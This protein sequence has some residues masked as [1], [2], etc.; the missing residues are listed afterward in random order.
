MA[1]DPRFREHVFDDL[2]SGLKTNPRLESDPPG[3]EVDWIAWDSGFRKTG[4][5]VGD[6]ILAVDGAPIRKPA[7]LRELQRQLP[8]M[9]GQYAEQQEFADR[10]LKDGSPLR[11]RTRRRRSPGEGWEE[12]DVTGAVRADRTWITPSN[13]RLFGPGG[14]DQLANDGFDGPWSGWLE[15][16]EFEWSRILNGGWQGSV[17]TRM[18]LKSH[19]EEKSRVDFLVQR[20]PGPFAD[21]VR[22]D[23]ET[24]RVCLE[25]ERIELPPDALVFRTLGEKRAAQVAERA[26]AAWNTFQTAHAAEILPSFPKID[27]FRGDRSAVAGKWVVL[28]A[29]TPRQ[30][31]VDMG[32]GFLAWSDSGFWIFASA[33]SQ[34]MV[35]VF[36]AVHRY[37]KLVTPSIK[38]DVA[39]IGQIQSDPR[40]LAGSGRTAAGL[41]VLPVA[42]LAGGA[43]FVEVAAGHEWD[44]PFA[45]EEDLRGADPGALP[46]DASPREVVEAMI[47]AIKRGDQQ[48][49]A[50]LFAEWRAVPDAD[51]P[52]YYPSYA[53]GVG[54]DEDWIRSRRLLMDKVLD[55]RVRWVGD[56][57]VVIRGDE[58]PGLPNI[59]QIPVEVDHVGLF[60]GETRTFNSLE[61]HRNWSL[62]RRAGGPWRI[63]SRQ[64]L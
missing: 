5:K 8:R 57:R 56:P 26:A 6:L 4:L 12:Q 36:R 33:D 7:E 18:A 16:R 20:Y 62:Q 55:A 35:R 39:V 2:R 11:L 38:E 52:I 13:R 60:D 50:E 53:W 59:E 14:P 29:I 9:I 31:L 34:G 30:W 3:L 63:A 61:V 54:R 21:T 15:R 22:E 40:L 24:V 1:D 37:Q 45:G 51:R 58:A 46:E 23:W 32:R 25:G 27:P 17:Q 49:W 47:A 28:P 10:S 48:R 64:G 44:A 41:E 43:V 42:A 19:L